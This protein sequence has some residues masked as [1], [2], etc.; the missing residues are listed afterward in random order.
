MTK[1]N[2]KIGG[3]GFEYP[4]TFF[5]TCDSTLCY[6]CRKGRYI[7]GICECCGAHEPGSSGTTN[8][9]EDLKQLG[10]MIDD[11]MENQSQGYHKK[12]IQKG[13]LGEPSKIQEEFEEFMDSVEQ[14]N[15]VMALIELSDLIGAI[16]AYAE[17]NNITLEHLINMK[18]ATKRAF[19]TG[20]R[21]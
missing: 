13:I 15:P 8:Y 3:P 20:H 17:K 14:N 18:D 2:N 21:K 5:T 4:A 9:T 1:Y 10:S 11:A 6:L 16:E 19:K 12:I 7:K